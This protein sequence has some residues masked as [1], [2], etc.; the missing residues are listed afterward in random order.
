MEFKFN[1][2]W[3]DILIRNLLAMSTEKNTDNKIASRLDQIEKKL[4]VFVSQGA[5]PSVSGAGFHSMVRSDGEID[6]REVWN[7]VWN[8]KWI[9]ATTGLVF[10]IL[11]VFYA[12]SLSNIY[13][14]EAL[15]APA[16][17][18]SNGAL[19]ELGGQFGGFA[20][21]AG[22]NLGGGS[23]DKTTLA[24][25]VLKSR[26]FISE[27]IQKYDLLVPLMA[28]K[29]WDPSTDKLMFD[30]DIYDEANK[31]WVRDPK[32]PMTPEPSS[33]ESYKRF[34][35]LFTV[36][37]D[38][39]T[40]YVTVSI[41]FYSPNVAKHWLDLLT[42]E[43]NQE[44]KEREV[45]EAKRSIKYLNE[46]LEKTALADMKTVFYQLI[47]EQIKTVMFAEVRTEYVF[48]TID[49]AIAPEL[50]M[51][52]KRTLIVLLG[53][54]LGGVLSAFALILVPFLRAHR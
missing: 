46:Q 44:I 10:A 8:G 18:N 45:A 54:M 26:E 24:I 16:G 6:L 47:E 42:Q 31:K 13:K 17:E 37:Q 30:S 41:E 12:L 11:S 33:Q 29:N 51:K 1:L 3:L 39:I 25:E 9:I 22:I 15:L 40:S 5:V 27:F 4:E 49:P 20:S 19:A 43:I 32:P 14:S 36:S 28:A 2:N 7:V 35:E 21:L 52:P 38:K 23:M 53:M 48:K 50:K 34:I